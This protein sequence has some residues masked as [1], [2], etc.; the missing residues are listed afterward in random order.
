DGAVQVVRRARVTRHDGV[1]HERHLPVDAGPRAIAAGRVVAAYGAVIDRKATRIHV[2][3]AARLRGVIGDS[4]A[5]DGQSGTVT[6]VKR[7]AAPDVGRRVAG[8]G[9]V[10]DRGDAGVNVDASP[11]NAYVVRDRTALHHERP[12]RAV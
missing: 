10:G 1:P 8:D 6:L 5:L 4:A 11:V 3:A 12:A 7:E 2:N 9:A